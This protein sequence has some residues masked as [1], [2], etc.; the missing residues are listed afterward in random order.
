MKSKSTQKHVYLCLTPF[1]VLFSLGLVNANNVKDAVIIY[2][3]DFSLL[4]D[5][6]LNGIDVIHDVKSI[7]FL[8]FQLRGKCT[9]YCANYKMLKS[10][11]LVKLFKPQKCISF[12]DGMGTRWGEGYFYINDSS[13]TKSLILKL[14]LEPTYLSFWKN[15]IDKHYTCYRVGKTCLNKNTQ[16]LNLNFLNVNC[17]PRDVKYGKDTLVILG[18]PYDEDNILSGVDF[19]DMLTSLSSQ[20]KGFDSIVYYTHP[21]ERKSDNFFRSFNGNIHVVSN[22]CTSEHFVMKYAPESTIVG[23]YSSTLLNLKAL[24]FEN[25]FNFSSNK[26]DVAIGESEKLKY[27]FSQSGVEFYK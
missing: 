24:G 19:S 6:E 16:F 7:T 26:L 13:K 23:F 14:M 8:G 4:S 12:D 11:I 10:R 5:I 17:K 27:F 2:L 1:H 20:A 18:S 3:G 9:F 22:F 15:K 21:R 25:I